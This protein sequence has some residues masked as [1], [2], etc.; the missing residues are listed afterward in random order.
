MLH[1]CLFVKVFNFRYNPKTDRLIPS[2]FTIDTNEI[3]TLG[4]L[5]IR[6][7]RTLGLVRYKQISET[8]FECNNLTIINFI[9]YIFGP[10]NERHLTAILLI[11]QFA[12]TLAAFF[13]RYGLSQVFY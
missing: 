9:L 3:G 5:M 6:I 10:T 12:C 1:S 4:A 13:I 8:Q 7:L 11:I 2:T